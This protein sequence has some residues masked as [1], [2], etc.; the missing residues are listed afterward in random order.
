MEID[1]RDSKLVFLKYLKIRKNAVYIKNFAKIESLCEVM[2][3]TKKS[4]I[5]KLKKLSN[6]SRAWAG[7]TDK[8][9]VHQTH[10]T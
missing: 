10:S 6:Y 7:I 3:N 2:E 4:M 8:K 5:D 9:R 1:I